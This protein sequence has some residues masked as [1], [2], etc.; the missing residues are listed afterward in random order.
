LLN[1]GE[2]DLAG[3]AIQAGAY[4]CLF[5]EHLTTGLLVNELHHL[6]Q[7]RQTQARLTQVTAQLEAAQVRV[8]T[9]IERNADGILVVDELGT[10]RFANPAAQTMFGLPVSQLVGR[11]FGFPITAQQT[12]EID[13]VNSIANADSMVAEMRVAPIEWDGRQAFVAS[14]RDITDRKQ[15]EEQLTLLLTAIQS[16]EEGVVITNANL[17]APGPQIVFVNNGFLRMTRYTAAELIGQSP[18]LLQG[19]KTD[20][21]VLAQLK[22]TLLQ[23]QSSTGETYNYRKDGSYYQVEWRIWPVFDD[24]GR[25]THYIAIQ[26]D[27]T[28]IRLMEEQLRQAQK[29]EA[30]GR[31]A[32]GVAHDFNNLLTVILNC[33]EFILSG[34][35][36]T[37]PFFN[38]VLDIKKTSE[39]AAAL[40]RQLLTLSRKQVLNPKVVD[41]NA[42]IIDFEKLLRRVI[43]EDI[44]LTITLQPSPA[45]IKI[46]PVHLEQIIMNLVLNARQAMPT[47]GHLTIETTTIKAGQLPE[48]RNLNHE[49]DSLTM[50]VVSDTGIGMDASTRTRIFDPFFTTKAWGDGLGL[51]IVHSIVTQSSGHITVS[52]EPAQGAQFKVFFPQVKIAPEVYLPPTPLPTPAISK[53]ILLVEDEERVRNVIS[54][55]LRLAGYTVFE[56]QNGVEALK[57]FRESEILIDLVITDMIMPIMG[58]SQLINNLHNIQPGLPVLCISGYPD[59][60]FNEENLSN[61]PAAFLYKPFTPAQLIFKV[62]QILE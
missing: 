24:L 10:I 53:T 8:H 59:D 48:L 30:L 17:E 15:R 27:V 26:R 43:G 41:L 2:A 35:D 4:Q 61:P 46:D 51:A 12:T 42:V 6:A 39:R 28:E 23:G 9:L 11:P 25:V 7:Q 18:R 57:I 49:V 13:I 21:E 44:H 32:G 62:S 16:V 34:I 60:R 3:Q 1:F 14:L 38:D 58:G 31:L 20:R 19:E 54:R 36:E 29:M 55:G 5:K 50:L 40:T 37:S 33:V 45:W 22:N 52:S 47:G 56:A